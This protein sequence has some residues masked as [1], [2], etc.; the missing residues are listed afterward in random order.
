MMETSECMRGRRSIRA[1]LPEVPAP[2]VVRELLDEARWAPSWGNSQGWHVYVLTG[3]ALDK[4]K[5][6]YVKQSRE[7]TDAEPDFQMPTRY[8]WPE[9]VLAR[10]NL[11]RPGETWSPPPGPT[12]WEMYGAPYLLLFAVDQGFVPTYACFDSAL[13]IENV[14]LAAY[15]RGLGTVIMAVAVRYPEVLREVLPDTDG[16]RFV[17]GV[18]LGVPD[19]EAS[20]NS[21][22][23]AR[24]DVDDI[25]TWVSH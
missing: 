12:I 8:Q 22:E 9:N 14:C 24:A 5:A 17:V 21:A 23:R 20:Q 25:V 11:V 15:D 1:F 18:A 4:V 10:M 2:A 16:Q 3:S 7:G 13:L 6:A 19:P